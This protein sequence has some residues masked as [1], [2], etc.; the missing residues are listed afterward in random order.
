VYIYTHD[1]IG[2]GEDGPTHQPVEQ[3][4][5]LRSVPGLITLRPADANEV[6]AVWRV[7][8]ELKSQPACLALSRQPLPTFDRKLYASADGVARGAYI[9]ADAKAG[10]PDVILVGTGSEVA[11]C[12][13]AYERLSGEGIAARVV[14]MPSWELFEQQDQAYQDSVFPPDVLARVSVEAGSVIGWDRYVGARGARIGMHTF[15][16]SAPIGDVMK[17]FGFTVDNILA[18]AK[19]QLSRTKGRAS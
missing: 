5:A 14:S 12:V 7:I 6:T 2:L 19:Q 10:A 11:I 16:A 1:S 17:R 3:L 15:G 4:I 9:M 8:M 13:E 18:A